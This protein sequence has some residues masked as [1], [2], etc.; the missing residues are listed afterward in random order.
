MNKTELEMIDLLK[1]GKEKYGYVSVKAEFEAEGTRVDELLRLIDISQKADLQLTVK[2]GGCE[3][4]RDLMESKQFGVDYIVAPMVE[5]GYALS[6]YILAKNS[7]YSEFEQKHTDFLVNIETKTAYE[8][9]EKI[10]NLAKNNINGLV[11]GRVDFSESLGVG[12]D[13]IHSEDVTSK[14]LEIAS[15][16]KKNNLDLVVGGAVSSDSIEVLKRINEVYL[17]RFET[18]K[19]VFEASAVEDI[20][21]NEGL[22]N[23]V[24][25]ELL[26]LQNKKAYYSVIEKEDDLRIKM[27]N[28]RWQVLNK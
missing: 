13:G 17:T 7:V 15:I 20:S 4:K 18:R 24:H 10:S 14:V 21:I 2:I 8:N 11:F 1:R 12:R 9:R 5:T 6:K 26:W 19:I 23:A 25:F 16:C 27:L 28:D 3:A 22:Y